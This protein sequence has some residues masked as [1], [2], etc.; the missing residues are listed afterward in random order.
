MKAL[1]TLIRLQRRTLNELRKQLG[2]LERQRAQLIQA[3]LRLSEELQHEIDLATALPEMGN[4]FGN[5]SQRI[6]RRQQDISKEV[7]K[8]DLAAEEVRK[9]IAEAFSET[10]KYEI[11]LDNWNRMQLAEQNRKDTILLDDMGIQQFR[12]IKEEGTSA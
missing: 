7:R 1:K 9:K 6:Q 8:V 10:K 3:S 12:R 5:F 4:F 2:D 11:A